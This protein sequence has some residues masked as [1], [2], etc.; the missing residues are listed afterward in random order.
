M[1]HAQLWK[2]LEPSSLRH[3][4]GNTEQSDRL[5]RRTLEANK[6]L[7]DRTNNPNVMPSHGH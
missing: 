1:S 6:V 7:Y 3:A 5:Y 4:L 2:W